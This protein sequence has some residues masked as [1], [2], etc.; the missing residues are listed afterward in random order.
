[1]SRTPKLGPATL[2]PIKRPAAPHRQ[3]THRTRAVNLTVNGLAR[4]ITVEPRMTLL[5]ALRENLALTGTKRHATRRVWRM[6]GARRWRRVLSCMTLAAMM[7]GKK[8]KRSKDWRR[9][10]CSTRSS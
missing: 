7:E 9:M 2:R 1:M 3:V 5:D 6:H 4:T 10:A 8:I